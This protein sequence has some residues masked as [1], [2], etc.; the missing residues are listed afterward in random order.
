MTTEAGEFTVADAA[1]IRSVIQRVA[2]GPELSKNISYAEARATMHALLDGS[3]D[4]VQAAIFLIGLRMKRETNDEMKG[5]LDACR[6]RCVTQAI[7]VVDLV[8]VADPYNGY[9][10]TLPASLFVLPTLAACGVPAYSHGVEFMGPK[11]GVTHHTVLKALGADPLRD[12]NDVCDDLANPSIGWAYLDQQVFCPALH[13]L[14]ELRTRIVKRPVLTT[15]ETLCGPLKSTG[16]TH[17]MT[18]F[19]HK[20]YPPIY[21]MLARH[22]G[23]DS[24]LLVRGT[25]GGIIPS[26]RQRGRVVR[27]GGGDPDLA[28][29]DREIA[30]VVDVDVDVEVD[31]EPQD[32]KL[33]REFRAADVPDDMRLADPALKTVDRVG[34]KW[35]IDEYSNACARAGVEAMRGQTGVAQ[36]AIVFGTALALWHVGRV[37]SPADGAEQARVAIKSG[38]ALS[39]LEAGTGEKLR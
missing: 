4:P 10:R 26:F 22:V 38:A 19:V 7:D 11:F 18:G 36:D 25:E 37:S 39:H 15:V 20:P 9:N 8:D 3:A 17:F 27:F 13:A 16:R 1:L 32:M 21:T 29:T 14:T 5:V 6:D 35:D 30:A 34:L 12:A 28:A 33:R 31:I 2:T 23:F 24:A